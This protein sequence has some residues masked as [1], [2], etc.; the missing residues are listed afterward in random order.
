MSGDFFDSN[1][2]VY[3][4]DDVDLDKRHR[5]SSLLEESVDRNAATISFQV[6]QEVLNTVTRKVALPARPERAR[7]ML[8]E[9]LGPLWRVMPSLRLYEE[10]L[11][12]HGRYQYGFY[13]SLIIAAGLQAGCDRLFTED[14]H[15]GQTI[16]GLRIENPFATTNF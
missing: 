15:N 10:A 1:V 6:V 3:L 7:F 13:D 2:L 9:V 5:A 4:F 11:R 12:I 16:E 8:D 14:L